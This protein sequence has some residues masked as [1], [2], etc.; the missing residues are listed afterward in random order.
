MILS[1]FLSLFKQG[2]VTA[3][4]HMKNLLEMAMADGHYDPAEDDLLH[5]IASKNGIS[6]NKLEQ[7]RGTRDQIEFVVPDDESEKFRQLFDLIHMMVVDEDVDQEEFRLSI[8]F[9]K[10]FGYDVNRAE[11]IVESI[12]SNISAGNNW[13]ETQKRMEWI[14]N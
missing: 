4:S 2:K 13:E 10:K 3:H 11:E 8:V 6:K 5:T 7:I 9:A 14:L 12:A 1:E